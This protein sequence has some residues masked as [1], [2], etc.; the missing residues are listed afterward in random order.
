M[1]LPCSPLPSPDRLGVTIDESGAPVAVLVLCPDQLVISVEVS[2]W[3]DGSLVPIWGA[4][5]TGVPPTDGRIPLGQPSPGFLEV[6]PLTKALGPN[7]DLSVSVETAP[8]EPG[9]GNV[10]AFQTSELQTGK[11]WDDHS[12]KS[13]DVF[14][15]FARRNAPCPGEPLPLPTQP[16]LPWPVTHALLVSSGALIAS[17]IYARMRQRKVR[18]P[19]PDSE[20]PTDGFGGFRAA[21]RRGS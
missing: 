14:D 6:L 16:I 4:I 21:A 10:E 3:V 1:F 9:Y 17:T 18:P 7:E 11:I 5:A 2:A 15:A 20:T 8:S 12:L 13:P 19:R